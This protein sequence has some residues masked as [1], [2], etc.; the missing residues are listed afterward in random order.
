MA[1]IIG[2]IL[3]VFFTLVSPIIKIL[4]LPIN[5]LTLGLFSLVMNGL[6]F[7]LLSLFVPGFTV[8]TFLAACIGALVVSIVNWFFH[9]L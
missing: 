4:T 3:L 6:V 9:I 8:A 2:A 5:I 7:Y 1:L